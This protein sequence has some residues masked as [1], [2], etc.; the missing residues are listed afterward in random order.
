MNCW[1]I[2]KQCSTNILYTLVQGLPNLRVFIMFTTYL[3]LAIQVNITR[4]SAY[5]SS[6]YQSV[7]CLQNTFLDKGDKGKKAI[8]QL[9]NFRMFTTENIKENGVMQQK[10]FFTMF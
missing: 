7:I 3:L 2:F 9:N 6:L 5:F 1:P 10:S 8:N 4:F